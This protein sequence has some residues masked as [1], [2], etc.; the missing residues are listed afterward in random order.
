MGIET[1]VYSNINLVA[2]S[3]DGGVNWRFGFL[4]KADVEHFY[5]PD[6]AKE[7]NKYLDY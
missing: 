4:R 5:P 3:Q 7:M 2:E 1:P 6:T